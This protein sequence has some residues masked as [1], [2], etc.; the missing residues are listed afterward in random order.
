MLQLTALIYLKN[1]VGH[2]TNVCPRLT[3]AM[4]MHN[5]AKQYL[6][7]VIHFMLLYIF[8]WLGLYFPEGQEV[9]KIGVLKT[10]ERFV[11][12]LVRE[13]SRSFRESI[14]HCKIFKRR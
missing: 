10:K 4:D 14:K 9:G 13:I 2:F 3:K 5:S 8:F 11:Y 12:Y 1:D 7:F 6:Y